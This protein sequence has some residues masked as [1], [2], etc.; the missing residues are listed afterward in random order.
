MKNINLNCIMLALL[1][2]SVF[3]WT[4]DNGSI[5]EKEHENETSAPESPSEESKLKPAGNKEAQIQLF[6]AL[7]SDDTS[8]ELKEILL[9][10]SS[11][12]HS[13]ARFADILLQHNHIDLEATLIALKNRADPNDWEESDVRPY[14]PSPL[15]MAT[16]SGNH[17]L[18]QLLLA[19]GADPNRGSLLYGSPLRTA[20]THGYIEIIELL[21]ESGADIKI[22]RVLSQ[23]MSSK[24]LVFL[25]LFVNY[26]LNLNNHEIVKEVSS[27]LESYLCFPYT[28][29]FAHHS[30][31]TQESLKQRKQ[32][33]KIFISFIFSGAY[34]DEVLHP[35]FRKIA[36]KIG[37]RESSFLYQ[38]P[39]GMT[40]PVLKRLQKLISTDPTSQEISRLVNNAFALAAAYDLEQIIKF[41]IDHNAVSENALIEA[42][43]A[44]TTIGNL[45]ILKTLRP[46]ISN[47]LLLKLTKKY[48]RIAAVQLHSDIV[49]YFLKLTNE[50]SDKPFDI[51]PVNKF[52]TNLLRNK[53]L[54][55]NKKT[56][57]LYIQSLLWNYFLNY[58][59]TQRYFG[60]L[61][62][63]LRYN[64]GRFI[65]SGQKPLS[66]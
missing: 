27:C 44:A 3:T 42:F 30:Q 45:S 65:V 6:H 23:L 47:T 19:Y 22:E 11:F 14:M 51:I 58:N 33:E 4:M 64:I 21:L 36:E 56:I 53:Y 40:E 62:P 57:Y 9:N 7:V 66:Q 46:L 61:M 16:E 10:D 32:V 59:P 1:G 41:L 2:C 38:I 63:E 31:I 43:N 12:S 55:P 35:I 28:S 37:M 24:G 17:K 49:Q 13:L 18:A 39:L 20:M 50:I 5:E 48:L 52:L 54:D 8:K 26:G 25:R 34:K 15:W 60:Q 29:L